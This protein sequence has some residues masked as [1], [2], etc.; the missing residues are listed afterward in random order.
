MMQK[1]VRKIGALLLL[2]LSLGVCSTPAMAYQIR[3]SYARISAVAGETLTSGQVV[4]I[5]DADGLAY[6][7]DADD[8]A[9]RPA[10]GIIGRGGA[11]G[12]TVEI[13]VQ[14]VVSGWTTLSEGA[15][16]YL[17]GTAGAVTQSAPAWN[18][19]IGVAINTTTYYFNFS[20]YVDT[21]AITALGT[22]SQ[23]L[24]FE[25]STAD[26]YEGTLTLTDPTAD[27]TFTFPDAT[28]TV[29]LLSAASHNYGAAAVD[30]TLTTAEA[31]ATYIAVSNANGAVNAILPAATAGKQHF[32][33]NNSG[34]T[35]TF[36]VT[37]G[38][39]GTVATGK[40]ALYID[41]GTDVIE[42]YEKP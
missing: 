4:N 32:I 35:L 3:Q 38:T 25:G 27:R 8:A 23:A 22:Q 2:L 31:Q 18:Q 20:N 41:N 34:Q 40:Y 1:F 16:C 29:D 5:K 37:G 10:V 11:A 26:A 33:Y 36:K 39:G 15:L 21:S 9:L 19:P 17:S 14:G 12:A 42:L 28:G 6:K 7:A 13:V 24:V 30:W